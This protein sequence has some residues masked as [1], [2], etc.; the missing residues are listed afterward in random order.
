MRLKTEE[1][2]AS[3]LRAMADNW[4]LAT[5]PI[6]SSQLGSTL[7]VLC[8]AKLPLVIENTDSRTGLARVPILS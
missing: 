8:F 6:L 3:L 5:E 1:E 4:I 2:E 7:G